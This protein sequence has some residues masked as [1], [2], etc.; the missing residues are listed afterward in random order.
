[1]WA[2]KLKAPISIC[3]TELNIIYRE[4]RSL[5][6]KMFHLDHFSNISI[7]FYPASKL[8]FYFH[9]KKYFLS[10]NLKCLIAFLL[11][12]FLEGKKKTYSFSRRKK[13]VEALTR[14][15]LSVERTP[16]YL[17]SRKCGLCRM[18]AFKRSLAMSPT[19]RTYDTFQSMPLTTL[20]IE[21]KVV[22]NLKKSWL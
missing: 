1:M 21:T 6:G 10:F 14:P 15:F 7:C 9:L 12:L 4:W 20:N 19:W 5:G 3:Q 13:S 16:S 22:C 11:S 17:Y 18:A 2:V 8:Y